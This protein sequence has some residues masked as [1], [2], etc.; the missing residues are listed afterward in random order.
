MP[1]HGRTH[2]YRLFDKE[3]QLLY[4]G[5][6]WFAQ[7]RIDAHMRGAPW[8]DEIARYEIETHPTRKAA[9]FAESEAINTEFPRYNKQGRRADPKS[10]AIARK[11]A[12]EKVKGEARQVLR[13]RKKAVDAARVRLEASIAQGREAGL[14]LAEL[15][16]LSGCAN[17]DLRKILA[18]PAAD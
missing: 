5:I 7:V 1:H 6:S 3:D 9:A 8:R 17:G 15:A 2:L 12:A 14:T 13:R 4:V 10:A 16:E 18:S 11:Q